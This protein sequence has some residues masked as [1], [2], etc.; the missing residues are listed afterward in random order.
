MI[1]QGT[2]PLFEYSFLYRVVKCG[3]T[4]PLKEYILGALCL[5]ISWSGSCGENF[6]NTILQESE[7]FSIFITSVEY[8][9]LPELKSL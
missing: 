7:G 5:S 2:I 9:N 8:K 3:T 1:L 6:K 4:I